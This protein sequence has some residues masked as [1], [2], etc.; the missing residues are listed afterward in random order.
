MLYLSFLTFHNECLP[1]CL[2]WE[3]IN[4]GWLHI[5]ITDTEKLAETRLTLKV[6]VLTQETAVTYHPPLKYE[7]V[8][9]HCDHHDDLQGLPVSPS[10]LLLTELHL[11]NAASVGGDIGH[12]QSSSR[13]IVRI[14]A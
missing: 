10:P 2:T 1:Q 12:L 5:T 13:N 7:E 8:R 14:V 11:D 6:L 9:T 3:Q 4:D